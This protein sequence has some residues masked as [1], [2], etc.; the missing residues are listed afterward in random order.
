M[1]RASCTDRAALYAAAFP[2]LPPLSTHGRWLY[3]V[4]VLG[5]D[6]RGSGYYGAYP[7]GFLKR[8]MA[9][10]PDP[11]NVLH[12]F[13]GSLPASPDYTRF[14]IRET[15]PDVCGDAHRMSSYFT[16]S[17]FDLIV[18][19]PPYSVEDAEHYGAPMVNRNQVVRECVKV[20]RPGGHLVWLDQ[21]WPM[22]RKAELHL[23]GTIG[24]VRS[25]NHRVRAVFFFERV[26]SRSGG[27]PSEAKRTPARKPMKR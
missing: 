10:F 16:P 21:A 25:T 1:S 11:G 3:G 9:M 26:A 15:T 22:F 2:T 24:I 19:D 12:L 8:L 6:Y 17:S 27:E 5:N 18:A 4:W 7:P 13:S 14:D 23:W 20:L